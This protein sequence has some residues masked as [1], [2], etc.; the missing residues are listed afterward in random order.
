MFRVGLQI[1][2]TQ[3]SMSHWNEIVLVTL[4][5]EVEGVFDIG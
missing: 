5:K 3:V 4:Q 1:A 2:D